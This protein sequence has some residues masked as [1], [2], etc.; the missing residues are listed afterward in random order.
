[1]GCSWED[2]ERLTEEGA[3]SLSSSHTPSSA[4]TWEF[5]HMKPKDRNQFVQ[6][7]TEID[8]GLGRNIQ[9]ASICVPRSNKCPGDPCKPFAGHSGDLISAY[10]IENG[11]FP[12]I[13]D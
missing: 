9:H 8:E 4:L 3:V 12:L 13:T 2:N 5:S 6:W 10:V 7:C 11:V 1:M